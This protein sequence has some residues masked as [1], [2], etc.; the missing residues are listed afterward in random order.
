MMTIMRYEKGH[1]QN[2]R[3]KIIEAAAA[4]F[5]KNG[6]E[7]IGVASLM[8]QAGLTHGGFYSHFKS[9]EELVQEVIEFASGQVTLTALRNDGKALEKV[10][11]HYLRPSHR[12]HAE[13]GCPIACLIG[14]MPRRKKETQS[15]FSAKLSDMVAL[16]EQLLPEE[17]TGEARTKSAMAITSVLVGALQMARATTDPAAS[18]QILEAGIEAALALARH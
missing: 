9:K 7:G 17:K 3:Q 14:E 8:S 2:T 16:F 4:E 11:R 15:R 18:D 1:K 13:S 5:R 6:T 10:I 12:D